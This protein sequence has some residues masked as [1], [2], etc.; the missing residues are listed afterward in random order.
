MANCKYCG[1]KFNWGN[2]GDRW[3]ALV[4]VGEEDALERAYQDEDGNLR[5]AH[6]LICI[7]GGSVKVTKLAKSIPA[8]ALM[9]SVDTDTGEITHGFP[10]IEQPEGSHDNRSD[11]SQHSPG[12]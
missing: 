10:S 3:V 4:P 12:A 8:S 11:Q 7:G 5:A 9:K 1:Q 6:R 2:T